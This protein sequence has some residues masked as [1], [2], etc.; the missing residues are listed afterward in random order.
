M[1][2]KK[3]EAIKFFIEKIIEPFMP[4][5]I[6]HIGSNCE[7]KDNNY[8][9]E[10]DFDLIIIVNDEIDNYEYSKQISPILKSTII[11]FNI[12][13]NAYPIKETVYKE[14]KSEFLNN[15][16]KNSIELWKS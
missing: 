12:M 11:Q 13:I 5:K 15:V 2:N 10:S 16:R 6:L 4:I 8:N 14:G 9:Y 7:N 1:E 3:D